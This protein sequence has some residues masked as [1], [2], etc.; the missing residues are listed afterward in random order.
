MKKFFVLAAALVL[1]AA[2]AL[3]A[4]ITGTPHDLSGVGAGTDQICVFCHTPHGANTTVTTAPLWNR[5]D[6][7]AGAWAQYST[8]TYNGGTQNWNLGSMPLCF[9]CHDGVVADTEMVNVPGSATITSYSLVNANSI[10]SGDTA[11]MSNDH[12]V[13]F[14]YAAAQ[15]IDAELVDSADAGV[16]ALIPNGIVECASC[17]DV[18]DNTNEPFLIMDNAGSVLCKTC[19]IK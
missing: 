13:G 8:A 10:I 2:P 17:H 5:T 11:E 6:F 3:A 15:A 9:S 12:P 19:H 16:D 1:F 7:T 14:D 4:N 18:H